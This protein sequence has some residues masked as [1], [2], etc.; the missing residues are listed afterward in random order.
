MLRDVKRYP[1]GLRVPAAAL[2]KLIIDTLAARLRDET[3]LTSMV[4]QIDE[5]SRI[6]QV[7]DAASVLANEVEQQPIM[8]TGILNKLIRRIG[9]STKTIKLQVD[10][11]AVLKQLLPNGTDGTPP[12][13]MEPVLEIAIAGQFIRCGKQVR[14]VIGNDD[15]VQAK[16]D[17][18]LIQEVV[19][20]Q[21]WFDDLLNGRA[22]S[23]TELAKRDKCSAS[24]ISR[25][26]NLA[27]LAP[28]ILQSI[29][30]GT[31]PRS[32]TQERLSEHQQQLFMLHGRC[33]PT[34]RPSRHRPSEGR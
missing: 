13:V 21:R 14:L 25:K 11:V 2:E 1:D 34:T 16:P 23:I 3:W 10:M 32:L 5:A 24:Y 19:R 18:R 31:Q 26:I 20:A 7:I 15:I 4:S 30:A 8:K 22:S 33:P 9:V 27:F 12:E 28:D 17:D 29:I 6:N